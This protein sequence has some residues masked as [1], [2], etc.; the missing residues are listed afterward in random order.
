MTRR[1]MRDSHWFMA[2]AVVLLTPLLVLADPPSAG[3]QLRFKLSLV[4]TGNYQHTGPKTI[5]QGAMYL[6]IKQAVDNSY[7]T[8]YVVVSDQILTGLQKVNRLDP[9]SQQ[10]MA[11]YNA[12][13]KEQADRVYHS[14]DDLRKKGPGA[15]RSG[16]PAMNPI[17]MMNNP[18]MMQKIMA[19]GQDQA[20]KQKIAMEMMAQQQAQSSGPGAQVQA[21]I[22]AISDACIK[23][24]NK[25]GSKGYEQCMDAEGEKRSTV[26][27]S[28]ADNEAEV[29]ELPD[30]YLLYSNLT[31]EKNGDRFMDCQY[32]AHAK[33]NESGTYCAISDGEG[34][35]QYG[36]ASGTTKGE[37]DFKQKPEMVQFNMTPCSMAEAA[38]DT[39][40]NLFWGGFISMAEPELVQ[41]GAQGGRY[42]SSVDRKI[43]GWVK[44]AL[45]GVPASGTKTQKFGYQTAKLTWSITRE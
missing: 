12:T 45:Q 31:A 13:V 39:K 4:V 14:A 40:T 25:M 30:R 10:E 21:D 15:A 1:W 37:G 27:R 5:P 38:F 8:E 26:K 29:P 9:A 41:T 16:M 32:K 44:S 28:A 20:C 17:A 35:G 22:Q 19:C 24:G 34:G 6:T 33:V 11:D 43:E 2:V 3:K 18:Q 7:S 23:K 42:G 36:E